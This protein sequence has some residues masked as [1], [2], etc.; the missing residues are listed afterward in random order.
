MALN[1]IQRMGEWDVATSVSAIEGQFSICSIGTRIEKTTLEETK[2]AA[3]RWWLSV[4]KAKWEL[5]D[6]LAVAKGR[7]VSAHAHHTGEY[8]IYRTGGTLLHRGTIPYDGR[9]THDET[10]RLAQ[11]ATEQWLRDF[12]RLGDAT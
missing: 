8:C 5:G 10:L 4:G 7:S 11:Q 9:R 2:A 12:V 3:D 6:G 1:W